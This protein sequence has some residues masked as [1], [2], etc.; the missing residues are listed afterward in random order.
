MAIT[1]EITEVANVSRQ[2]CLRGSDIHTI[3]EVA[4]DMRNASDEHE[5]L[6][7][8]RRML[9]QDKRNVRAGHNEN[10]VRIFKDKICRLT[11]RGDMLTAG[12][13]FSE[14]ISAEHGNLDFKGAQWYALLAALDDLVNEGHLKRT[15]MRNYQRGSNGSHIEVYTVIAD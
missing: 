1:V 6:A 12:S 11:H 4:R 10:N 9:N 2:R 13:A 7:I 15:V 5:L 8:A 3:V 14:L